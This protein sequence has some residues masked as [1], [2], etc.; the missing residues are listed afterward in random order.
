MFGLT[1]LGIFHTLISLVAVVAGFAA[2][3]RNQRISPANALGR[4]YLWA[5]VITCV[6][7]FGIFQHGGFGKAHALGVVTLLVLLVAWLSRTP[8]FFGRAAR[9]VEAIGYSLTL[10]LHMI[11]G[12]TETTTRLPI[13][14]PLFASPDDPN[15]QKII[16]IAFGVFLVI[17]VAQVISLRS[18]SKGTGKLTRVELV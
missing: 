4:T 6:T 18:A 14:A 7:G 15:L 2:L 5:T 9:Y 11:P 10:L 1:T 12:F 13:G 17:F 16:G 3:A 8:R